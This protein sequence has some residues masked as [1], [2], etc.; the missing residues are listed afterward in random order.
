[1][2]H[3]ADKAAIARLHVSHIDVA[4]LAPI[5]VAAIVP[6][7]VAKIRISIVG[8]L[9]QAQLLAGRIPQTIAGRRQRFGWYFAQILHQ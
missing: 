8:L 5:G 3:L 2:L 9:G 6:L 7:I 4:P 1:M